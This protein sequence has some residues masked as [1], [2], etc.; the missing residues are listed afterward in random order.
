MPN[1]RSF[2]LVVLVWLLRAWALRCCWYVIF[3]AVFSSNRPEAGWSLTHQDRIS[4]AV[5]VC[6][7]HTVSSRF[8]PP[9]LARFCQEQITDRRQHQVPFQALVAP[10]FVLIQTKLTL[11]VLK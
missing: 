8:F 5:A 4:A 9:F 11:V 7:W 2:R 1:S 3:A 10:P 6:N